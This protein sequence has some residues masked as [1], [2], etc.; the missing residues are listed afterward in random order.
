MDIIIATFQITVPTTINFRKM[1]LTTAMSITNYCQLVKWWGLFIWRFSL[2]FIKMIILVWM[3]RSHQHVCPRIVCFKKK[4]LQFQIMIWL[5]L[6]E[7]INT[8]SFQKSTTMNAWPRFKN[9]NVWLSLWIIYCNKYLIPIGLIVL[10]IKHLKLGQT[11]N[12]EDSRVWRSI[13]SVIEFSKSI[14]YQSQ[15][16]Q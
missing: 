5:T 12:V 9:K 10:I 2:T 8:T 14:G 16:L 6:R 1:V 13:N 3:D 4:Q 7:K 11:P 15:R